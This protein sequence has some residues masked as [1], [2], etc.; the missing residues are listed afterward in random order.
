MRNTNPKNRKKPS[1]N[2]LLESKKLFL[3]VHLMDKSIKHRANS[4]VAI[5]IQKGTF[6]STR[7]QLVQEAIS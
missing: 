5:A 7:I 6:E 1:T 2:Q 4:S 3:E